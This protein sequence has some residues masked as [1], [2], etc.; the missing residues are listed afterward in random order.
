MAARGAAA[1]VRM[2]TASRLF[3][4]LHTALLP[5]SLAMAGMIAV[6]LAV[7]VRSIPSAAPAPGD[8][9]GAGPSAWAN[10]LSPIA[11]SDW[12][13]DRAAHLIERAGFGATPE[14]IRRL[15]ALTPRQAVDEL[16]DYESIPSGLNA[17]D[18]S[19]I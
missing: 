13:Y 6:A 7:P 8:S 18:E 2:H 4:L 10:D 17:F 3:R 16:V 11:A 19:I 1:G 15:A 5:R 9:V 12:S 14:E